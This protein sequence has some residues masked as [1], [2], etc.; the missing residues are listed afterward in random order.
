MK[1]IY[2]FIF[3][4]FSAC[5]SN[6]ENNIDDNMEFSEKMS[7]EEFKVNLKVYSKKSEYPNIDN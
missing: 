1:K 7:M 3:I 4:L 2:L 5:S 6:I